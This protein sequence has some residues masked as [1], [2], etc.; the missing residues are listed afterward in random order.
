MPGLGTLY[1]PFGGPGTP[2][3]GVGGIGSA[4]NFGI[5]AVIRTPP[6]L[7]LLPSDTLYP[8]P[9]LYPQGPIGVTIVAPASIPSAQAF[10]ILQI[11][12][13]PKTISNAGDISS[14]E[15]FG[16]P[17]VGTTISGVGGIGSA[18]AVGTPSLVRIAIGVGGIGSQESFGTPSIG[19]G[20][21]FVVSGVGNI[22]S[23]E[24]FGT[25]KFNFRIKL[26]GIPSAEAFGASTVYGIIEIRRSVYP[27]GGIE[28]NATFTGGIASE[29]TTG[30]LEPI[31]LTGNSTMPGEA[32]VTMGFVDEPETS[33]DTPEDEERTGGEDEYVTGGIEI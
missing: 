13:G 20:L 28:Q 17:S 15:A 21:F 2:V 12:A 24:A 14:A 23:A 25:P 1:T 5:P 31:N 26:T 8:D 30:A 7:G 16:Q 11:L 4:E 10:G 33:G 18:E 27:T 19:L 3:T 22:T 32:R 6:A 29:I 9:N